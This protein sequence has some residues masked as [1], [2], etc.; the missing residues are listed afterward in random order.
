MVALR[1]ADGQGEPQPGCAPRT[2]PIGVGFVLLQL[3]NLTAMKKQ[4]QMPKPAEQP[5]PDIGP[6]PT[7]ERP[8]RKRIALP[9]FSTRLLQEAQPVRLALIGATLAMGLCLHAQ[10]VPTPTTNPTGQ[11]TT[12]TPQP[13]TP[14][15]GW[16][17]F[18]D[19]VASE[20]RMSPEQLQQ[21]RAVDERFLNDYR[22]LGTDPASDPR[23]T[24]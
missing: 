7:L 18:D 3:P 2:K 16:V 17:M 10:N 14:Q 5:K 21:L 19:G 8:K 15:Q 9:V 20:L 6:G 12:T 13:V 24:I 1:Y 22:A 11:G 4:N 23:Y